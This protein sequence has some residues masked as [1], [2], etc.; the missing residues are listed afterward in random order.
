MQNIQTHSPPQVPNEGQQVLIVMSVDQFNEMMS[1][2]HRIAEA[3][4]NKPEPREAAAEVDNYGINP[5]AIYT[6]CDLRLMLDVCDKTTYRWRYDGLLEY[7]KGA[8]GVTGSKIWYFG[9]QIINFY[10]R[11]AVSK[12]LNPIKGIEKENPK[13]HV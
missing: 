7:Q 10:R 3:V 1:C 4:E 9:R 5:N 2:L 11:Y 13:G 12:N 8:C 6:D